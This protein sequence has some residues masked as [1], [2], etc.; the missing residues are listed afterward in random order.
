MQNRVLGYTA[1]LLA[2]WMNEGCAATGDD[3]HPAYPSASWSAQPSPAAGSGA[4]MSGAQ[5]TASINLA[6]NPGPAAYLSDGPGRALYMFAND[7][8]G[9]N[10]SSCSAA[11]LE[12]WPVFD[13]SPLTVGSGLTASDFTRFQRPDGAWQTAFKGR[14]L[15]R[16][17]AD[18]AGSSS[19]DG[20]GGR[21]Y[22]VRDY[23]VFV[24]AKTDLIPQGA[25]MP[26]P[27]MTNRVGRTVYAFMSDTAATSGKQPASACADKCLEAWP[28]WPAPAALESLILPASLKLAD[29]GTFERTSAAG[30]VKQLTYRGYPLYFHTPDVMPGATSGH[31]RGAWRAIDPAMF[32]ATSP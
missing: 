17:A 8:P 28:V 6:G 10:I 29:F 1:L 27:Y 24:A 16:F 30:T 3:D 5:S 11:C 2:I 7:V 20:V 14:P 19:G 22:L 23:N 26:A 32:A 25:S 15:Y 31:R 4:A 9:S 21:W 13:A 12:K 18:A